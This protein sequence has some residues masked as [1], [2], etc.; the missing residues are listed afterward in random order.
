MVELVQ[1][2]RNRWSNTKD[3][4]DPLSTCKAQMNNANVHAKDHE[5]SQLS[6]AFKCITNFQ[7]LEIFI[8]CTGFH[9][10]RTQ[11]GTSPNLDFYT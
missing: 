11:L 2:L 8:S 3:K 4:F 5:V 1:L 6:N 9:R 10:E 7:L